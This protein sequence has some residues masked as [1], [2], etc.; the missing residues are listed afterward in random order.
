MRS[1]VRHGLRG[2]FAV[3]ISFYL[4]SVF[5]EVTSQ[6]VDLALEIWQLELP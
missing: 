2:V 5:L 3:C 1:L 4:F 6:F